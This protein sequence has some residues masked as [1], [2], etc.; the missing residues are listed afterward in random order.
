MVC[1][2][3]P[4]NRR[5]S[6]ILEAVISVALLA[7]AMFALSK[8][9]QSAAAMS[10]QADLRL[11]A[12]VAAENVITRLQNV[13]AADLADAAN[14]AAQAVESNSNCQI[15]VDTHE[16]SSGSGT[17]VHLTVIATSGKNE[18]VKRHDWRLPTA[19]AAD[20]TG[21]AP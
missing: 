4:A 13:P 19:T 18:S 5:G 17:G 7:S 15:T 2:N 14:Q 20:A 11:S 1:R 9:S 8:L 21:E 12:Q 10:R 16:F 3:Q 6:S